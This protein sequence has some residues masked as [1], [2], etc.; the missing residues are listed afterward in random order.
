MSLLGSLDEYNL[1]E[2]DDND[3]DENT[4]DED[5]AS[6]SS[7]HSETTSSSSGSSDDHEVPE[8]SERD[9]VNE[10]AELNTCDSDTFTQCMEHMVAKKVSDQRRIAMD[11]QVVAKASRNAMKNIGKRKG[12]TSGNKA[13]SAVIGS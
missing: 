9:L 4:D 6:E 1:T 2:N 3:N 11:R 7:E 10:F 13:I 12:Q 5:S 8:E